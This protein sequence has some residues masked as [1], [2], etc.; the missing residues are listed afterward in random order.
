MNDGFGG[1]ICYCCIGSDIW[2]LRNIFKE[3]AFHAKMEK[4]YESCRKALVSEVRRSIYLV[5]T[6][7]PQFSTNTTVMAL[8]LHKVQ[9]K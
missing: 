5:V 7:R 9:F 2:V 1:V 3:N 4:T 6:S 8:A